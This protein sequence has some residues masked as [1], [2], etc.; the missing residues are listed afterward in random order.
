[1]LQSWE[2]REAKLRLTDC[3]GDWLR[4][5]TSDR[6]VHNNS[7]LSYRTRRY[8]IIWISMD[9]NYR[10]VINLLFASPILF[11]L[12]ILKTGKILQHWDKTRKC[13]TCVARHS[14]RKWLTQNQAV[15]DYINPTSNPK[16]WFKK[17]SL[18]MKRLHF[19]FCNI[20]LVI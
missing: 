1:M 19:R 9:R 7:S 17:S 20:S 10:E 3:A 16:V 6:T 8:D 15:A 2:Y 11:Y 14:K 5:I 18:I 13:S 4:T 12:N